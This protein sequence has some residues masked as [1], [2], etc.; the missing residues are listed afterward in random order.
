[1][2]M[3]TGTVYKVRQENYR[4][5]DGITVPQRGI[6]LHIRETTRTG[7]VFD[8]YVKFRVA[9]EE[10]SARADELHEGE[11]VSLGYALSG[12]LI[13]DRQTG[14]EQADCF[15]RVNCLRIV[16]HCREIPE[17]NDTFYDGET[18]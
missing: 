8:D 5:K 14:E 1:M 11:R 4:R 16:P 9:G 3:L 2:N 17:P 15:T 13:A 7:R 18:E 12:T 6:I 10:M